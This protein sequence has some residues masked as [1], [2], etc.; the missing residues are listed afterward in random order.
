MDRVDKSGLIG[1]EWIYKDTSGYTKDLQGST[2][3]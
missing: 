1:I 2:R 3:I